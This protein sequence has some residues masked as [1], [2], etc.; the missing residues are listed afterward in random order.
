MQTLR[1][2]PEDLSAKIV[3]VR[4][5]VDVL[6]RTKQDQNPPAAS[7]TLSTIKYLY[8]SDAK[9]ILVG[10]WSVTFDSKIPTVE[11]VAG[12]FGR[13][14]LASYLFYRLCICDSSMHVLLLYMPVHPKAIILDYC[15]E[16]CLIT[17]TFFVFF[18][19][20]FFPSPI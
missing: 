8:R 14:H 7:C 17:D 10:N 12:I 15:L 19:L 6:L 13:S 2:F 18:R 16:Q 3:M 5:E 20:S 1:D 9:I 4:I 11:F